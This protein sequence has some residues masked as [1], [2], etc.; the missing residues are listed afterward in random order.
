MCGGGG[1]GGGQ[2]LSEVKDGGQKK[3]TYKMNTEC[4][5]LVIQQLQLDQYIRSQLHEP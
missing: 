3:K 2:V 5:S 4:T 1:R